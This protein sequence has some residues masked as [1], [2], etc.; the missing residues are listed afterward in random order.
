[1]HIVLTTILGASMVLPT[2]AVE[3]VV[4]MDYLACNPERQF[5]R[6]ERL[7]LSGDTTALQ[8]FTAGALLSN[9][10]VSLKTGTSVFPA[11]AV[12]PDQAGRTRPRDQQNPIR[13]G[14]GHPTRLSYITVAYIPPTATKFFWRSAASNPS[15]FFKFCKSR[16]PTSRRK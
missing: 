10:C 7:R 8:E 6:A 3:R 11:K 5:D 16:S 15:I 9:T 2:Q 1:M 12:P 13:F 14:S 4:K